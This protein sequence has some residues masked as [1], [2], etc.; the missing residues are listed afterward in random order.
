MLRAF[1]QLVSRIV[2]RFGKVLK[3]QRN[4]GKGETRIGRLGRKRRGFI[5]TKDIFEK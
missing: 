1:V 4:F 3:C 5:K 2:I